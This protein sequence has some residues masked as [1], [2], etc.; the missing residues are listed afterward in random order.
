[1]W[2]TRYNTF[3]INTVSSYNIT[4]GPEKTSLKSVLNCSKLAKSAKINY[5]SEAF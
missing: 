2:L 5:E 4:Q 1:M 3:N